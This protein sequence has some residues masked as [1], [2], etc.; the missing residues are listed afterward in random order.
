[1]KNSKTDLIVL[2]TAKAKPGKEAELERALREV[3][4]PTRQQPGCVQFT[5]LRAA[6]DKSSL[7]GY[8]RWASEEAHQ[9]HLAGAH[10]QK[11][12]ARMAD[13]LAVP[14]SIVSYQAID[15]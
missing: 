2:A 5:L 6:G 14:P 12:M 10:V 9:Q 1:M 4:G 7:V 11:L 15:E 3:A 8:E 13:I